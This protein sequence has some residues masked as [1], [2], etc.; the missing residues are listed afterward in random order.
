MNILANPPGK[1]IS[2]VGKFFRHWIFKNFFSRH[3]RSKD[4]VAR[5][6]RLIEIAKHQLSSLRSDAITSDNNI[7]CN[8]FTTFEDDTRTVRVF[9]IFHNLISGTNGDPQKVFGIVE[10]NHV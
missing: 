3:P 7:P 9:E 10:D 5:T 6:S 8:F 1:R 2:M 4:G